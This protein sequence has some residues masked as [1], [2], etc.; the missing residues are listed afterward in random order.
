M[1]AFISGEDLVKDENLK[2]QL[3]GDEPVLLSLEDLNDNIVSDVHNFIAD[4]NNIVV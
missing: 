2:V 4:I 1:I 3:L